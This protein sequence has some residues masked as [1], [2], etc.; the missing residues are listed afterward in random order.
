[1]KT[2][3]LT[4][5]KKSIDIRHYDRRTNYVAEH[6]R[7]VL[8]FTLIGLFYKFDFGTN[9]G[10]NLLTIQKSFV[11]NFDLRFNLNLQYNFDI[12]ETRC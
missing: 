1:M 4:V 3:R 2:I 11:D 8:F 9:N 6:K 7:T 12:V 5:L 10:F